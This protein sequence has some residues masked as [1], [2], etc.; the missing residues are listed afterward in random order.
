[1]WRHLLSEWFTDPGV[2]V[3][4]ARGVVLLS[5]REAQ[6]HDTSSV[7]RGAVP[8]A[9]PKYQRILARKAQRSAS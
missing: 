3:L 2:V 9:A 7:V 5:D 8:A 4:S 6:A 1:M